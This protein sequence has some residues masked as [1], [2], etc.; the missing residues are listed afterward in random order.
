MKLNIDT[1]ND[2]L[3][4]LDIEAKGEREVESALSFLRG[5][6]TNEESQAAAKQQQDAYG[7]NI[8]TLDNMAEALAILN[9]D[10]NSRLELAKFVRRITNMSLKESRDWVD[11][12][13]TRWP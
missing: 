10:K 11:A 3:V 12:H 5:F 6:L 13:F 4:L 1:K 2:K 9:Q 7:N 8:V